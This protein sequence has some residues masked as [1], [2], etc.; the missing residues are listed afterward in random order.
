M[1][2]CKNCKSEVDPDELECFH[3]MEAHEIDF[4][5][6]WKEIGLEYV[7]I[8]HVKRLCERAWEAG[9]K[10]GYIDG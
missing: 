4:D 8:D 7:G 1:L 9:E 6:W 3:C 10:M 2:E 5:T